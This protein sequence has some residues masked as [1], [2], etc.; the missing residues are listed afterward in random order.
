MKP[1]RRQRGS[2]L[3]EFTLV[4]IPVIFVVIST[5]EMSRGMWL[6]QTL[7]HAA[8]Q[9]TRY[10]V[11][12]GENCVMYSNNCALEVPEL[13][14]VIEQA[15]VGLNASRLQVSLM[16]TTRTISGTLQ[17]LK[18]N[19]AGV[20]WPTFAKGVTP[21]DDGGAKGQPVRVVLRYPLTS[22]LVM[23]WPGA[24]TSSIATVDLPAS[25]AETIEF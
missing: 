24:G 17:D 16:S 15:S 19:Y 20:Y 12:R 4:G 11:V 23:F 6:Y 18:T 1:F 9:A 13:A 21:R 22:V 25:S 10:A 2:A 14:G 8:K 3:I 7:A 5:F